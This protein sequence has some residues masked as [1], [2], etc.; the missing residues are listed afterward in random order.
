MKTFYK[1]KK[2]EEEE[3]EQG[4]AMTFECG[5]ETKFIV[6]LDDAIRPPTLESIKDNLEE[7]ENTTEK[8]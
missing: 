7:R 5:L 6:L 8:S 3:E 1:K 2:K 4:V